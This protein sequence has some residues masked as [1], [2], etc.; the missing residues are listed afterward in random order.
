[1]TKLVVDLP[2]LI[3]NESIQEFAI[4][5]AERYAQEAK[6]TILKNHQYKDEEVLTSVVPIID[7]V[8]YAAKLHGLYQKQR[9]GSRF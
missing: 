8:F 3:R 5:A 7:L 6:N 4:R 1:M 9:C 2:K